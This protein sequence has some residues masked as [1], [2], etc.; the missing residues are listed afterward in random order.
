M[1][2]SFVA[3]KC[4]CLFV[5]FKHCRYSRYMAVKSTDGSN[6]CVTVVCSLG[7][8]CILTQHCFSSIGSDISKCHRPRKNQCYIKR[9]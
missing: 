6:C 1:V 4:D 9:V 5:C 8:H 2:S 7:V 3:S